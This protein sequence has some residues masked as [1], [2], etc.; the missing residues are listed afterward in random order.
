MGVYIK[1]FDFPKAC[2]FCDF[3]R[4]YNEPNHGYFC[5]ALA[6][7]LDKTTEIIQTQRDKHCPLVEVKPHGR[8][9]DADALIRQMNQ[10]VVETNNVRYAWVDEMDISLADTIIEADNTQNMRDESEEED[11]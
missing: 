3:C 6:A 1:G 11:G 5:C 7:D 2:W 8:L 4:A 9:I 10:Q